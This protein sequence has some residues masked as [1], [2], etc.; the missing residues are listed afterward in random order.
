MIIHEYGAVDP[1]TVITSVLSTV[2]SI[3]NKPQAPPT[4]VGSPGIF[5]IPRTVALVGGGVLVLGAA[6]LFISRKRRSSR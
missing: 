4:N 6:A 3:F 5:G 1:G 2:S